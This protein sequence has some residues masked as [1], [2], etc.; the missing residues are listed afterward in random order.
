[1][2]I[3][4]LLVAVDFSECSFDVVRRAAQIAQAF[5]A[6][7][8]ILHVIRRPTSVPAETPLPLVDPGLGTPTTVGAHLARDAE[9][10]MPRFLVTA[11][12]EGVTGTWLVREG[13]VV[14]VILESAEQLHADMIV[15][16][17]HGRHGLAR[18]LQ[19]SVAEAVVRGSRVPVMTVRSEHKA[20]CAARS[21]NWCTAGM[22]PA[23][24]D[25]D[26]EQ[27]G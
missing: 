23:E 14:E 15:V 1:M 4:K 12:N 5:D 25:V 7:L 27:F 19:G 26:S 20:T 13:P 8:E 17:T 16:G 24:L 6:R 10:R 3:R 11:Q 22:S 18:A 2:T 9:A 21:C